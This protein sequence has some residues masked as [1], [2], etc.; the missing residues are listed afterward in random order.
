MTNLLLA[1]ASL[2]YHGRRYTPGAQTERRGEAGP[3]RDLRGGMAAPATFPMKHHAG[4][5]RRLMRAP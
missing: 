3:V 1:K 5:S 4:G 2:R